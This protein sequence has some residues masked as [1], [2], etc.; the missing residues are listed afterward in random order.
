MT[1][2]VIERTLQEAEGMFSRLPKLTVEHE[3]YEFLV[4]EI[5][6]ELDNVDKLVRNR[7]MSITSEERA[8]YDA[9]IHDIRVG[10][11]SPINSIKEHKELMERRRKFSADRNWRI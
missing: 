5:S 8:R 10:L 11:L 2:L 3:N 6:K 7:L 9:R 4:T 1:D